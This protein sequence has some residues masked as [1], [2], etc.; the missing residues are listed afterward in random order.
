MTFP[1]VERTRGEYVAS[2][3]PARIDLD[4]V[5]GYLREP[6]W[7]AIAGSIPW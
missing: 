6:Y 4:A 2:S 7:A 1:I 3:D 5:H